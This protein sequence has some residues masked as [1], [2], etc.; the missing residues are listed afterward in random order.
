M[1]TIN[2]DAATTPDNPV[3]AT[4]PITEDMDALDPETQWY[5]YKPGPQTLFLNPPGGNR[6]RTVRAFWERFNEESRKFY[7]SCWVGFNLDQLRFVHDGWLVIPKK[8]I[9]YIDPVTGSVGASSPQIGSFL[10]LRGQAS[11]APFDTPEF[12]LGNLA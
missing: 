9:R 7:A 5:D 8:R 4:Y 2:T 11:L 12:T 3:L 10:L 6:G 1:G